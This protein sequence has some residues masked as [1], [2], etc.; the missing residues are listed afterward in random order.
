MLVKRNL[1][2][3]SLPGLCLH[4]AVCCSHLYL[5]LCSLYN[6]AA[7]SGAKGNGRCYR[8][9]KVDRGTSR[10]KSCFNRNFPSITPEKFTNNKWG[11]MIRLGQKETYYFSDF[12]V[13]KNS[14]VSLKDLF[15]LISNYFLR[16]LI[17][18]VKW[19]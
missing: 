14:P 6:T 1:K 5:G 18:P 11:S 17:F 4:F 12:I 15:C 9:R 16:H 8:R 7:Q 13:W 2:L 19:N 3:K 10:K